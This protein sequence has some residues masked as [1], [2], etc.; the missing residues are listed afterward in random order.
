MKVT[1]KGLRNEH[2][3]EFTHVK[4]ESIRKG[5]D[6]LVE[7]KTRVK[8]PNY[9]PFKV[10]ARSLKHTGELCPKLEKILNSKPQ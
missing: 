9:T 7:V 5:E 8:N 4:T 6:G 10:W 1:M 3:R 2:R